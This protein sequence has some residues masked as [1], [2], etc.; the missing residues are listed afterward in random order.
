LY[1]RLVDLS[2]VAK[3]Y[4]LKDCTKILRFLTSGVNNDAAFFIALIICHFCKKL[5]VQSAVK[6]I[7]WQKKQFRCHPP[8]RH[9]VAL[10]A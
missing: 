9:I 8:S 10:N 3:L 2:V 1:I 4:L 6:L 5:K 7:W